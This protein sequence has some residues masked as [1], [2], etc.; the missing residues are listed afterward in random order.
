MYK[1][2]IHL[3][4]H[5]TATST[6]QKDFFPACQDLNY[7]PTYKFRE[8]RIFTNAVIGTDPV[9][10]NPQAVKDP[11]ASFMNSN[12]PNLLS[13]ESFS[14]PPWSGIIDPGIDYRTPIL[15]KLKIIFPK[16]KLILVI[17]RQDRLAKSLYRQYIKSGGSASLARFYGKKKP[18]WTVPMISTDRFRF[19]PYLAELKRLFPS[20]T[21]VLPFELFVEDSKI[22]LKKIVEFIGIKMPDIALT[23]RNATRFG[24]LGMEVT[25]LLNRVLPF[26]SIIRED[27]LIPGFPIIQ[28][29]GRFRLVNP[30]T[31]IHDRWPTLYSIS[32]KREKEYYQICMEIFDSV[33]EDNRLVDERYKLD[34]KKY[35]YY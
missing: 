32:N 14:G 22:F 16:A 19:S 20:R 15:H 18:W 24:P 29:S 6:L 25:R 2:I 5:K 4:L 27:A 11:L 28:R 1:I 33:K 35:G 21:L 30:V 13:F 31:Y 23:R 34:L 8:I 17:R 3:G 12:K 10:L 7:L 9:Y 26:R